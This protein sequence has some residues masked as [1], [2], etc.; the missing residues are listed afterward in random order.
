[1]GATKR[2]AHIY[3][4]EFCTYIT[5]QD[6]Q[7]S[8]LAEFEPGNLYLEDKRRS[9]EKGVNGLFSDSDSSYIV[10]S[11]CCCER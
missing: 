10:R 3:I 7:E 6:L 8:E 2:S 9:T 1:M 11:R 4:I 5:N